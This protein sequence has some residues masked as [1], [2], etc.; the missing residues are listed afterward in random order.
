M[1]NEFLWQNLYS[2]SLKDVNYVLENSAAIILIIMGNLYTEK[3]VSVIYYWNIKHL[4][5][6]LKRTRTPVY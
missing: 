1:N 6:A 2:I 5:V 4:Q 3:C